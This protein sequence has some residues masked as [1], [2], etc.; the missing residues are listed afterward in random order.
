[1]TAVV[2]QTITDPSRKIHSDLMNHSVIML[3]SQMMPR[4]LLDHGYPLFGFHFL[5][6]SLFLLFVED[7]FPNL[8][9]NNVKLQNKARNVS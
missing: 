3:L 1:M 2:Q 4:V 8:R 7:S 5:A 6:L 9:I